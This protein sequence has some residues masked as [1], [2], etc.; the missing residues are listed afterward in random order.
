MGRYVRVLRLFWTT[1][2]AA[3]ME[4]R[5]NFLLAAIN[6]VGLL[7]GAI[8]E[9]SLLFRGRLDGRLGG[10]T[11]H[12][13]MVVVGLFIV[14]D[15]FST[16]FL[17]PNLSK[18][19]R[20]VQD[21]TLD[22][23][24]LKPIDSQFWVS[25]RNVSP[26]GLPAIVFGIGVLSYAAAGMGLGPLDMLRGLLPLGLALGILYSLWFILSATGVWFVKIYNVTEV[27]R[28]LL[29]AG[30]F[31]MAAYP[32]AYRFF[33]TFI[34][35][36]AFLTTV[37]AEAVLGRATVGWLIAAAAV[38]AGLLLAARWFWRFA[39]RYYTSASS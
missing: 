27:L 18:I 14:F 23:V 17:V 9:L 10:W 25:T 34:V 21:G 24:L 26:W 16:S 11:W 1:A 38:T 19:V 37:P 35:P 32:L 15:G 12:E 28:A 8:F 29:E 7:L 36:V 13:A 2:V 20:Q 30:R 22:F 39:L 6:S 5:L 31:P 33:F 4:Y 3:E